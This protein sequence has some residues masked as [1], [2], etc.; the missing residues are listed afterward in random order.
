MTFVGGRAQNG[1]E[2][3]V[4]TKTLLPDAQHLRCDGIRWDGDRVTVL[5]SSSAPSATCPTCGRASNRV[6]S[7]YERRLQDLPWQGIAICLLWSSRRF[8]CDNARCRQRIFAERLPEVAAPRGRKTARLVT[9]LRALA[10]ACG[11]EVGAQLAQRLEMPTSPDTLLRE[12]R[13]TTCECKNRVRVLGVDDWALRRGQRYGTVL[14]DLELHEP[15]DLLPE[16]SSESFATWLKRHP[17]VEVIARDRGEHYVKGAA[18]GAPQAQQVADRW[19]LLHNLSQMLAR[20]V[21]RFPKELSRTMRQV[22]DAKSTNEWNPPQPGNAEISAFSSAADPPPVQR[23]RR[24]RWVEDYQRVIELRQQNR[25]RRAIARE[26]GLDR[27]TVRRWLDAGCLP[28]LARR[29]RPRKVRAWLPYLEARWQAGCRNA[30]TLTTELQARGFA[31][32]YDT[33]RRLVAGWREAGANNTAHIRR[34]PP[35]SPTSVAW[36]LFK[37][38]SDRTDEQR[39]FVDSFCHEC[40]PVAIATALAN[41]F[42]SIIRDRKPNELQDWLERASSPQ[43]PVEFRRFTKGLE[44][45]LEAIRAALSLEWSNGQTEGQVNRIKM[46]KRQMYGRAKFDLLRRRVLARRA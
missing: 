38:P 4:Q 30:V 16:R 25:S 42:A 5:I 20:V 3:I 23:Q 31:G 10:L 41:E 43:V 17:E 28:E 6:H 45:D 1:Q 12:I 39:R 33:I 14:V 7:H 37:P 29:G 26:L 44:E 18:M 19:H 32:S 2:A 22:V 21:Q 40:P 34:L 13:R 8:F 35:P 46:I 9:T 24:P 36:W 27:A 11:G 15:I